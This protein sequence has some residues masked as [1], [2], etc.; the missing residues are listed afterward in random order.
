MT[1]DISIRV[2]DSAGRG[3]G[4]V[5]VTVWIYQFAA[6]GS[7]DFWT[8]GDGWVHFSRDF[9]LGAELSI[10]VDGSERVRRGPIRETYG[11]TLG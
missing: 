8:D 10:S 9:D 1:R 5:R 7:L 6:G 11:I 4:R 2:T 3:A